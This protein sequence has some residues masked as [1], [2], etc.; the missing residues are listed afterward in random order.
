MFDRK[1]K[2]KITL[3]SILVFSLVVFIIFLTMDGMLPQ[4]QMWIQGGK[5][6]NLNFFIKLLFILSLAASIFVSKRLGFV[7][8]L[9][10]SIL[11]FL[12]YLAL[13]C[14]IQVF[15]Y[16]LT[17]VLYG[18]NAYFLT[19]LLLLMTSF[20][21]PVR[22]KLKIRKLLEISMMAALSFGLTQ[23]ILN[24]PILRVASEDRNF[25]IPSYVF[26]G[27]G[28][29][30]VR[31]FSI[32]SNA[33]SF[34]VF[35]LFMFGYYSRKLI[36]G[37]NLLSKG[38]SGG[39]LLIVLVCIFA[40]FTRNVYLGFIL[41]VPA[42]VM[43]AKGLK[44]MLYALPVFSLIL[45]FAASRGSTSLVGSGLID[46]S[47]LGVRWEFWISE[48]KNLVRTDVLKLLLGEG[49]YQ[50]ENLSSYSLV[51]IDNSYLVMI[52]YQGVIGLI[53]LFIVYAFG[54][55]YIL[56]LRKSTINAGIVSVLCAVPAMAVFNILI[57][58]VPLYIM[59]AI[60][61]DRIS[62]GDQE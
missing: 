53:L 31:S 35:L 50:S 11:V 48:I 43:Y 40:T 17:Y 62:P 49:R 10:F 45:G 6:S 44:K 25:V 18:F 61:F 12:F 55:R 20:I 16:D 23:L 30:R 34:G 59:L 47:S 24:V 26:L 41:S 27:F 28:D 1:M 8:T 51:T 3:Q 14:Y 33:L 58:Q 36:K 4:L 54:F 60:L 39:I 46:Q 5:Y 21:N 22:S 13:N 2:R 57:S 29:Y 52:T 9:N 19:F 32:F 15:Y 7:P 42:V 38:L 37:T 56:T